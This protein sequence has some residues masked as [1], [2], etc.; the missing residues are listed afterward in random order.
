MCSKHL[1]WGSTVYTTNHFQLNSEELDKCVCLY[2]IYET[3]LKTAIKRRDRRE[4][5]FCLD[6]YLG[7]SHYFSLHGPIQLQQFETA[8]YNCV[9]KSI[10]TMQA[11]TFACSFDGR[12][13]GFVLDIK[14]GFSLYDIAT[15]VGHWMEFA[16]VLGSLALYLAVWI[17]RFGELL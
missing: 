17:R 13:A 9:Y 7:Q 8:Y 2:K 11:R 1:R 5:V 6:T 16:F 15:K 3:A 14:Q 4:H 12:P 10:Q